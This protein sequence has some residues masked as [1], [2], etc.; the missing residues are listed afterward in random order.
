VDG[1]DVEGADIYLSTTDNVNI[2]GIGGQVQGRD[3]I[4]CELAT[5]G[6]STDCAAVS[7]YFDGSADLDPPPPNGNS[8]LDAVDRP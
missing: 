3:V 2:P 6:T 7:L 4:R 1:A 8:N 5:T